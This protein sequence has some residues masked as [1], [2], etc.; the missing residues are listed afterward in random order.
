MTSIKRHKEKIQEHIEEIQDAIDIGIEKRPATIGFHTVT[1]VVEMLEMY[2]HKK[3]LI[4]PGK[5][6]KHDWF[7]RPK[8]EQKI[9][10]LIERKL[11]VT[12]KDKEKIYN[13]FYTLEENRNNLIYGKATKE[14][15]EIVVNTFQKIKDIMTQKLKEEGVEI[16]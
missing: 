5:I 3:E 11:P 2:L 1:C 12:F 8:K 7:K 6:I 4:G 15:I 13:L 9:D 10:P 16:E 14:Q